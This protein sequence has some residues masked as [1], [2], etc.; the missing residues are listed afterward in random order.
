[1][2]YV[3]D[4]AMAI[5]VSLHEAEQVVVMIERLGPIV[6]ENL[7][8]QFVA[9]VPGSEWAVDPAAAQGKEAIGDLVEAARTTIQVI[10]FELQFVGSPT[11]LRL[12]ADAIDE[13]MIA[14]ARELAN[15]L[16]LGRIESAWDSYYRDGTASDAYRAAID[17]R[18]TALLELADYASP[19]AAALRDLA[20]AIEDYY[21]KLR[22]LAVELSILAVSLA[23]AIAGAPTIFLL[24]LGLLGILGSMVALALSI[25]DLCASTASTS[26]SVTDALLRKTPPWPASLR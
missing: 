5:G 4:V 13:G 18:D 6:I 2:S 1:M 20:D 23:A 14:P 26:S 21:T 16:V 8:A 7:R 3:D 19:V 9:Q 10:R 17:G 24:V 15:E 11:R 25:S 22:D 12:A